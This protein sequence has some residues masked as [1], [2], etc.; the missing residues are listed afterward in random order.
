MKNRRWSNN[1]KH[2][3]PFTWSTS[4]CS[5]LGFVIDSGADD[6]G[7]GSCHIRLYL[8]RAV[9]ICELPRIVRDYRVRHSAKSWSAEDIARIGR[10]WYEEVFPREYGF[11][12]IDGDL[13][14]Y[15]GAQTH[16]SRTDQNKVFFLPWRAWRFIRTSLYDLKGLHFWTELDSHRAA[17]G[18]SIAVK[19]ACPKALF[20]FEDFDGQKII[21]TTHIEE[22]EWH[23]G[24]GVFKW[25]SWFR[26]PKIHRTLDLEF[27]KEVGPEKGSWKGG[28]VGTSIEMLPGEL[29]EAA[30]K[31]Y[32]E[33]EHRSKSRRYRVRYLGIAA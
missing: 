33:R 22:S 10:D 28:T 29:H 2:F 16:D 11:A 24:E 17:W 14:T 8:F 32:C 31:R 30:L 21:A 23:F 27:N 12:F 18:A 25:L 3:W 15:F 7:S 6:G 4:E 26:K 1:D 5:R 19:A 9:L 13:H 20:E